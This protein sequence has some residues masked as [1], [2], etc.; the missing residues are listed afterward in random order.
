MTD[1]VTGPTTRR[2][3]GTGQP[4]G[5][6]IF[7]RSTPPWGIPLLAAA[8]AAVVWTVA[9][10][11]GADLQARTGDGLREVG[12]LDVV[13]AG[14]VAGLLGW[15]VRA[16]LRRLTGDG[17]RT[18]LVLCGVVLLVSLAGP[19]GAATREATGFL[20]AEHVAVG[21]TIAL[22]LRRAVPSRP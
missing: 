18:W 9:T 19:L 6:G 2:G 14:L 1:Q 5:G 22:G 21:A 10:L 17:E 7:R 3:H 20:V 15:G 12:L 11:S 16:L 8:V 13:V 4:R